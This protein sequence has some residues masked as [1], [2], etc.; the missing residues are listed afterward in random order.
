LRAELISEG[1]IRESARIQSNTNKYAADKSKEVSKRLN[2]FMLSK[3]KYKFLTTIVIII[4]HFTYV[5][6]TTTT[7]AATASAA[8]AAAD[9]NN[10]NKSSS[11]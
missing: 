2:E 9:D 1:P 10:N 3:F 6:N 7:T 4:I 8:A 11:V 5:F